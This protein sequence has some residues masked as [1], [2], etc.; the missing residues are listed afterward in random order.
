MEK[1]KRKTRIMEN[2][3]IKAVHDDDIISL[4]RSLQLYDLVSD[5]KIKCAFCEGAITVDNLDAII[6]DDGKIVLSC[7]NATCH[8]KL[9]VGNC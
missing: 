8:A 5:G 1:S 4:L 2:N 7:N 6:P 9:L 3:T